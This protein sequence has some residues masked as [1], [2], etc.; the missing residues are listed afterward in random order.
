MKTQRLKSEKLL[1]L[2]IMQLITIPCAGPCRSRLPSPLLGSALRIPVIHFEALGP[3]GPTVA[4][5]PS[6]QPLPRTKLRIHR[7]TG[8]NPSV[9]LYRSLT[10]SAKLPATHAEAP[11]S[12]FNGKQPKLG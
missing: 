5:S 7:P 4:K 2:Y 8:P 10:N 3:L 6:A 11:C 9:K 1:S 12:N